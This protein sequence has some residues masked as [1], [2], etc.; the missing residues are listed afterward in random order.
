MKCTK[1]E[2]RAI[3]HRFH[4]LFILCDKYDSFQH[5]IFKSCCPLILESIGKVRLDIRCI[6]A[7]KD[8]PRQLTGTSDIAM[9]CIVLNCI[10]S[11]FWRAARG[12]KRF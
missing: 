3:L 5:S 8:T 7:K 12:L 2:T 4:I 11:Q 1:Y 6:V 10:K 9:L